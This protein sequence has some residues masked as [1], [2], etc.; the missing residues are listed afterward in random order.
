MKTV[1]IIHDSEAN[2]FIIDR[3]NTQLIRNF[4]RSATETEFVFEG[5]DRKITAMYF[6]S[7]SGRVKMVKVMGK[8]GHLT[9]FVNEFISGMLKSDNVEVK[10]DESSFASKFYEF[11][12]VSQDLPDTLVV[13]DEVSLKYDEFEL[14]FTTGELLIVHTP[15]HGPIASESKFYTMDTG[16][17]DITKDVIPLCIEYANE[18]HRV[19]RERF[20]KYLAEKKAQRQ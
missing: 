20:D 16:S 12:R 8:G 4:V 18:V 5:Q 10:C 3:F 14:H 6:G 19:Q 1:I 13:T 9:K 2:V 15:E 11:I 7:G 17:I